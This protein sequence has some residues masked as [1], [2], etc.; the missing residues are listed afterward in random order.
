VS[1]NPEEG[2]PRLAWGMY[3][4][5]VLAGAIITCLCAATIASAVLL[6]VKEGLTIFRR[7]TTP[8]DPQV[9]AL[10]ADVAPGKPQTIL[11]IG[12]DRRK[13]EALQ[14]H[15]PPT[16]SDTMILVRLDP[17]QRATGLMS[18]PRDL[19]V[20]IPGHGRQKLNAAFAYGEDRLT[21]RTVRNLLKIPIH[22]YVRVTFWGFR[23]AV[24]RLGCVYVD[25]DHKYYNDNSP[26]NGGGPPYAAI[27]V[28][29]GYQRLCGPDALDY[30]RYRHLDNDL[31]RAARQ[32][33]FLGEAKNQIGVTSVFSD[34]KELLR[35]F[36]QSVGTDIDSNSAI[37]SLLK[38]V[39]VSAD[40]PIQEVQFPAQDA[41][42]GSGNVVIGPTALK[43][44][45]KSFL[46][47]RATQGPR[48]VAKSTTAKR[49]KRKRRSQPIAVAG[50]IRNRDASENIAAPLQV[51]L[52][53]LP[54]Y[55]PTLMSATGSY[56]VNDSR[57]YDIVDRTGKRH[58]AYR[59][60]AYEGRI[61]QYYGI[62]GTDWRSPP[63]LDNPS[64]SVTSGGRTL[65]LF[66]DGG[67]LKL[68]AWR[69]RRGSYWVS[70]TLLRTLTNK[71]MLA[72]A[73]SARTLGGR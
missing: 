63:I 43:R 49:S 21:L 12:D 73:R 39:A 42:D 62:Q 70:N 8:I 65:K 66:Y 6:E 40:K 45:V 55:Y 59:I 3:K 47:A 44:T 34:R 27:D 9:K 36:G 4:R 46:A 38:L 14:K 72:L 13:S 57:A 16:R 1:R 19:V 41:G 25:V 67:R 22:H 52:E 15:P 58:R 64:S 26:P 53:H 33:S 23:G 71:Q 56:R 35:I 7:S 48:G 51:K 28:G 61:G 68:V 11:V 10:L 54:V 32:Q 69:T 17:H 20:D 5:F 31:I 60:V 30:V 18:L 2:P 24:D 37:F 50:L 29:A